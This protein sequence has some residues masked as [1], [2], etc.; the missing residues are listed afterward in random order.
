DAAGLDRGGPDGEVAGE[1][2]DEDGDEA[3]EA[4]VDR[5]V[6]ADRPVLLVV[7]PHVS[8]LEALGR[9][10]VELDGPELPLAADAVLH[11]EV[12]LRPVESAIAGV[13]HPVDTRL[14]DGGPQSGFRAIPHLVSADA[15]RRPGPEFRA[16]AQAERVV[17]L[18]DQLRAQLH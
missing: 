12:E 9:V 3:L 2:F 8:E 15:L 14:L 6:D 11:G 5:A 17:H 18:L 10:V 4:P 16:E 7:L 1:V 13:L